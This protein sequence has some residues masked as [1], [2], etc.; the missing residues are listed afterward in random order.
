MPNSSR[1]VPGLRFPGSSR[2]V[3]GRVSGVTNVII[4]LVLQHMIH[5]CCYFSGVSNIYFIDVGFPLE[6]TAFSPPIYEFHAKQFPGSSRVEVF[7]SEIVLSPLRFFS[8]LGFVF[9]F[10]ACW[11]WTL[12]FLVGSWFSVYFWPVDIGFV[13]C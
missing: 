2:V 12:D 13:V 4:S 7:I 5:R 3:P 9:F 8:C 11:P 1:V 10:L 6:I